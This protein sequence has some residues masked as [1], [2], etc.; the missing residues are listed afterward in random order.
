M[1]EVLA[2]IVAIER[3]SMDGPNPSSLDFGSPVSELALAWAEWLAVSHPEAKLHLNISTPN[4]SESEGRVEAL[5]LCAANP[6]EVHHADG[7][8]LLTSLRMLKATPGASTLLV[9]WIGHAVIRG[10]SRYL[11]H[12][13]SRNAS[14]LE[15]FDIDS[16]LVH[17]RSDDPPRTQIGV[18]ATCAQAFDAEPGHQRFSG[19]GEARCEQYFFHAATASVQAS[20]ST[21]E[22]TLASLALDSLKA[23][24]W[25]HSPETTGPQAEAFCQ[26]L[27]KRMSVLPSGPFLWEW[28]QVSG[29]QWSSVQSHPPA[30]PSHS[31]FAWS[32]AA[33][34]A[35]AVPAAGVLV[36]FGP[37]MP[38]PAW[39]VPIVPMVVAPFAIWVVRQL[40]QTRTWG[41]AVTV[42]RVG[43]VAT[44]ILAIAYTMLYVLLVDRPEGKGEAFIKGLECTAEAVR[45]F[46][47]D[48]PFLGHQ[49]LKDVGYVES[50]L[51]T[52]RSILAARSALVLSWYGLFIALA[53]CIAGFVHQRLESSKRTQASPGE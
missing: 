5:R 45:Q 19:Q 8:A 34:V 14:D 32:T 15:A 27:K 18:V 43:A 36:G 9:L 4:G 30:T 2:W 21:H 17:L 13:G 29:D 16:L 38:G 11:L 35:A 28:T 46:A 22:P 47:S 26:D 7:A 40:L 41:S 48:C 53:S 24:P 3:H 33:A 51:W 37:P 42:G 52:M 10:R 20:L 6:E 12:A 39:V 31:T 49:A 1:A 50:D 44:G 23:T 25:D